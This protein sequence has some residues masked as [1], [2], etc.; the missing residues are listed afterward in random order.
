VPLTALKAGVNLSSFL[1]DHAR[2]KV[3]EALKAKGLN[4][5]LSSLTNEEFDLFVSSLS[6]LNIVIEQDDTK[7]VISCE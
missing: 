2:E 7:V 3:N 5:D 4:F 6:D 1:P